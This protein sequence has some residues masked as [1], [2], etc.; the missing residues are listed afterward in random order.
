M[1]DFFK[2]GKKYTRSPLDYKRVRRQGKVAKYTGSSTRA[3]SMYYTTACPKHALQYAANLRVQKGELETIDSLVGK[4]R[5]TKIGPRNS[6]ARS[7]RVG[8]GGRVLVVGFTTATATA[9]FK[10]VSPV[11]CNSACSTA[12]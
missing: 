3:P 11:Q 9:N 6:H 12:P 7:W 1:V 4:V 10:L 8:R 2:L 5:K